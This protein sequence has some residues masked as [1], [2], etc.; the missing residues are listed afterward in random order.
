MEQMAMDLLE[1]PQLLASLVGGYMI[2][3]IYIYIIL[4]I[5]NPEF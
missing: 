3:D 1:G 2:Y 4:L 5:A